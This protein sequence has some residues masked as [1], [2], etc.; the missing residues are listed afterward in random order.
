[1]QGAA[2]LGYDT[3]EEALAD[4]A[5]QSTPNEEVD[6]KEGEYVFKRKPAAPSSE[7]SSEEDD[8]KKKKKKKEKK[9]PTATIKKAKKAAAAA[10]NKPT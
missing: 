1:M 8:A 2:E 9:D 10:K 7:D 6:Q 4:F 3:A 5:T